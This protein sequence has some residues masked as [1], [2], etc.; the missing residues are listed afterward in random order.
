M[1]LLHRFRLA[2]LARL[3]TLSKRSKP[4]DSTTASSRPGLRVRALLHW[5]FAFLLFLPYLYT[6]TD[7]H[8]RLMLGFSLR[9]LLQIYAVMAGVA[10]AFFVGFELHSWL[11]NRIP[12]KWRDSS[13]RITLGPVLAFGA[14]A[15]INLSILHL[16]W[17][18]P[19]A[20]LAAYHENFKW[21]WGSIAL[22]LA[23]WPGLWRI[24]LVLGRGSLL[25]L[26][27]LPV[28]FLMSLQGYP[29]ISGPPTPPP[30]VAAGEKPGLD[31]PSSHRG[32][33]YIFIFD[34]WDRLET[35]E[36]GPVERFPNL[37][38]LLAT[39]TMFELAQSTHNMTLHSIPAI[40]FQTDAPVKID[41][42]G[43]TWFENAGE[44]RLSTAH[45][46]LFGRL[47]SRGASRWIVGRDVPYSIL[48]GDQVDW[49][50][51][52]PFDTGQYLGLGE[53]VK[54]HLYKASFYGHFPFHRLLGLT[55]YPANFALEALSRQHDLTLRC[56]ENGGS[57]LVSVFHYLIPHSPF[58]YTR[59]GVRADYRTAVV[60]PVQGYADNLDY[61]DQMLGELVDAIRRA[62]QWDACTL[63]LTSDHG[64]SPPDTDQRRLDV[65]LIIKLPHQTEARVVR[66]PIRTTEF[67]EWIERQLATASP[68]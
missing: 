26:T 66:D 34:E 47:A 68:R 30:F 29:A 24:F 18:E 16:P 41:E 8:N 32:P 48:L 51:Q 67:V 10:S 37:S 54:A 64:T 57:N 60:D 7:G 56:I 63:V 20:V 12:E 36:R 19:D 21:I 59:H 42:H 3:R 13:R 23:T 28:I 25:V 62:G 33:T 65:P 43:N 2:R 38:R 9:G 55:H 4:A 15:A 49:V 17:Q 35:F 5:Q 58:F 6:L 11:V 44:W 53:M 1:P 39:S 31:A 52:V 14:C 50:D 40:L 27:P 46:S 22:G 45:E 61:L